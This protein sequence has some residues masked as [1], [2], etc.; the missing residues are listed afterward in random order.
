LISNP[1][2]LPLHSL[3]CHSLV[4]SSCRSP[5]E[6]PPGPTNRFR[7][8]FHL[9]SL[10]PDVNRCRIP[11]GTLWLIPL[12]ECALRDGIINLC[13]LRLGR[14]IKYGDSP[15]TTEYRILLLPLLP[16]QAFLACNCDNRLGCYY[17]SKHYHVIDSNCLQYIHWHL[18]FTRVQRPVTMSL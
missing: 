7:W 4:R 8:R 6:P 14:V 18:I 1:D 10:Q 12:L 17:P 16:R 15:V 11:L 2:T 13:Q 3:A 5:R 9:Y